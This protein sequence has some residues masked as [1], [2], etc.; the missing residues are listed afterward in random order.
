MPHRLAITGLYEASLLEYE[1]RAL[2][3]G[4]VLVRTEIA[5]GKHG[6]TFGMFDN[7]SFAGKRFDAER[8]IVVDDARPPAERLPSP[9]RPWTSGTSGLGVVE[10]VGTEVTRFA[11]GQRVLGLMD[12]RETNICPQN[13]LWP[14]GEIDPLLALCLEPAYVSFHC[15]RESNLRYGDRV[16]VIG[17]GA[18]GLLAV[19]IAQAAGAETIIAID[20]LP[21]RRA[22]AAAYGAEHTLDPRSGDVAVMARELTAGQGVDIAIE[23]SGV[24]AGLSAAIR[25]ARVGGLVCSAGFYQGEAQNLYLGREWHHNRLTMIVP[26]GCGW[27]HEPREYPY[28]HRQRALDTIVSMMRKGRLQAQG[29]VNKVYS[30]E[31]ATQVY[32]QI[33]ENPDAIIKFAVDLG[34]RE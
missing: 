24:Y 5:S 6:T 18:L 26:H 23:L 14:L 27:G 30:L 4:E 16:A 7:R 3:A 19:R 25:C 12:I 20:P 11:I 10:A 17:L 29:L 1:D 21:K 2:G 9:T 34:K 8:H 22:L 31:A 33:R 15:V 28:W 32:Q 13:N